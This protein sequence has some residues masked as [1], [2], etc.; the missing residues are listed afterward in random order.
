V[1]VHLMT[2]REAHPQCPEIAPGGLP[3]AVWAEG[4]LFVPRAF[5]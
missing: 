5:S 4:G 1:G 2:W 3:F